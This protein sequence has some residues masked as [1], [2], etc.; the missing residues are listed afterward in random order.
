MSPTSVANIDVE[1]QIG[2]WRLDL[3][4]V[5]VSAMVLFV[6]V[7]SY[8]LFMMYIAVCKYDPH[9]VVYML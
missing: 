2:F 4:K 5:I 3:Q 8:L 1:F 7:A 9:K 6:T